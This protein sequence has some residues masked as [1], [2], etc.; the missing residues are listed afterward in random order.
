MAGEDG[1]PTVKIIDFF[2]AARPICLL[3]VW[4]VF[5]IVQKYFDRNTSSGN[6]AFLILVGVSLITSGAYFINQIFD[7]EGDRINK[8]LGFLQRDLIKKSEMLAAYIAVSMIP[9]AVAFIY[10]YT[11]GLIFLILVVMG[12]LYSAPPF[13][14]KDRPLGG[15]L[16][17][18]LGYGF[19]VPLVVPG[20]IIS[21][22]IS[23]YYMLIFFFMM[24]S[25]GYLLTIIPDRAGDRLTGK[26][27]FAQSWSDRKILTIAFGLMSIAFYAA[28]SMEHLYLIFIV[29]CSLGFLLVAIIRPS[30]KIILFTCKFPILLLT[31]LAGYYYPTYLVFIVVLFILTR[32]YYKKRFNMVYPRIN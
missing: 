24:L 29:T 12:L 27:T 22:H 16:S 17:N 30:G 32:V 7:Y 11:T 3:P 1:G 28:F 23:N 15:L 8:K 20:F 4:S 18:G 6:D 19:F 10:N 21:G 2:F 9:M 26:K 14:L 5:L 13:R 31:L 25:A